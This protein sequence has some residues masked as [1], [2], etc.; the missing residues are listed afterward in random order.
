MSHINGTELTSLLLSLLHHC[1]NATTAKPPLNHTK[2]SAASQGVFYILLVL[3]MFSFFSFAVMFRFIRSRKLEGS[4]DPY[5]QY[6]AR[7][8]SQKRTPS[9]AAV[10][11]ARQVVEVS[12]SVIISNPA[13]EQESS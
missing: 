8:W 11:R 1:L 5:Q 10:T 9:T 13:T 6:I 4:Q 7:D 3:A 12:S 2:T